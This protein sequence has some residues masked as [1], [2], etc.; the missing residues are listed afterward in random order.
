MS[1]N[2]AE[3]GT[4]R[5][6]ISP[7]DREAFE[8]AL[9]RSWGRRLDASEDTERAPTRQHRTGP[10]DGAGL[11]NCGRTRGGRRFRRVSWLGAG[12]IF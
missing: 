5:G 7:Q 10:C 4:P 9:G 1:D 12:P 11:Q 6:R 2:D 8:R 3:H